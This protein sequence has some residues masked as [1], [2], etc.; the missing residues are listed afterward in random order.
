[1]A[2][3]DNYRRYFPDTC[4]FVVRYSSSE[5]GHI[6]HHVRDKQT[7]IAPDGVLPV[8]FPL[9]AKKIDFDNRGQI[10]VRD[11][12][13]HLF[14]GYLNNPKLTAEKIVDDWNRQPV[15]CTG[16]KG[17][18]DSDGALVHLGRM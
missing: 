7:K 11:K 8:G 12:R 9:G 1:M 6:S 4:K 10:L 5:T 14:A 16:D 18:L 15:Y 2:D 17:Y 13:E 3:V